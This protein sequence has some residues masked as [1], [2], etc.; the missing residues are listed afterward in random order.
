MLVAEALEQKGAIDL[1]VYL[2]SHGKANVTT[3]IQELPAGQTATY[4]AIRKLEKA[5][6]I[7]ENRQAGVP[8]SRMFYLT[9]KGTFVAKKLKE[10]VE[11]S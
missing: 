5:E 3:L 10:M 9:E 7:V 8:G 6:L 1:L 4:S 2:L 11:H